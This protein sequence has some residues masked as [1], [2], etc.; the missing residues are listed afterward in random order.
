M[1]FCVLTL[2][3]ALHTF[4]MFYSLLSLTLTFLFKFPSLF[5]FL[6]SIDMSVFLSGL[7]LALPVSAPAGSC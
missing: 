7:C 2:L 3:F 1:G 6:L 5:F 4:L